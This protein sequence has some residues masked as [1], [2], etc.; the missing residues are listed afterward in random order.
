ML[1]LFCPP[2]QSLANA[3]HFRES[4]KTI[5]V[6]RISTKPE[7]SYR[8]EAFRGKCWALARKVYKLLTSLPTE[9]T[10][11]FREITCYIMMIV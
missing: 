8:A 4:D 1:N 2:F 9:P 5:E 3:V 11:L 6:W 7:A 10:V